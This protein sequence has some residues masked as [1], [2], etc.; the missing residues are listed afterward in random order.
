MRDTVRENPVACVTTRFFSLTRNVKT[1]FDVFIGL[2]VDTLT[3][4]LVYPNIVFILKVSQFRNSKSL[5]FL[6]F[7]I[8][9]QKKFRFF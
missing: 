9:L 1:G 5:K 8:L 7:E 4:P 3:P 2:K 6:I